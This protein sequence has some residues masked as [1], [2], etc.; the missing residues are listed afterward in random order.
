MIDFVKIKLINTNPNVLLNNQL[1]DFKQMVSVNTGELSNNMVA[2]YKGM[3]FII[4]VSGTIIISGSLH[5][6]MNNGIHNYNDFSRIQLLEVIY[7]FTNTFNLYARNCTLINLEVGANVIPTI[8]TKELLKYLYMHFRKDFKY[9]DFKNGTFKQATYSEYY[10]KAYDKAAQ[11]NLTGELFRFEIKM[12]ASRIIN[13]KG[14]FNLED[15]MKTEVFNRLVKELFSKWQETL[16]YD[17][18]LIKKA[19]MDGDSY[20]KYL[21]WANPNFWINL[22]SNKKISRNKYSKEVNMYREFILYYNEYHIHF[23]ITKILQEKI[24]TLFLS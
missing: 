11:Y 7:L 6:Y 8:P 9:G 21:K 19:K 23:Q 24:I 4:Y 14:A 22:A 12:I 15:L 16:I 20:D 1:L 2:R 10:L 13:K 3:K 5:K 17:P 18:Y